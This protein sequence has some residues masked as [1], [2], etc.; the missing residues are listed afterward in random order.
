MY[1]VF[2]QSYSVIVTGEM[3]FSSSRWKLH[4][5]WTSFLMQ[6]PI[7][8]MSFAVFSENGYRCDFWIDKKIEHLNVLGKTDG[9]FVLGKAISEWKQLNWWQDSWGQPNYVVFVS[10]SLYCFSIKHFRIVGEEY[11]SFSLTCYFLLYSGKS[12]NIFQPYFLKKVI[13]WRVD[14]TLVVVLF[15]LLEMLFSV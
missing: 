2:L 3:K 5:D 4:F 12:R 15:L 7:N 8:I 1:C 13:K 9:I 11:L 10:V 6:S 14:S